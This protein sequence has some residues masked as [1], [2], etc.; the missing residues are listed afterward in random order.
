MYHSNINSICLE[1][2]NKM[3]GMLDT[4]RIL[5][6]T[7]EEELLAGKLLGDLGAD[8]I[9][10]ES[11]GG[12]NAR[13]IGPFYQDDIDPEKSLFWFAFNTSKKGVTLNLETTE[14]REIFKNLVKRSDCVIE[15]FPTGY[16][17]G[18]GI[19]YEDLEKLNSGIV[20]VSITPFGQSGPYKDYKASDIVTWAMGGEMYLSGDA[21]RPPV[22]VS[23]HSQSRMHA[24]VQASVGAVAALY[25][26]GLNG[27][28]QH[29]D[30]SVQECVAQVSHQ[31]STMM[32]DTNKE[33]LKRNERVSFGKV[34]VSRLWPCKDGYVIFSISTGAH[35]KRNNCPL[36]KLM[37]SKGVEDN[38]LFK[39][40]WENFSFG[41]TKQ[42]IID[43]IEEPIKKFFKM[44]T[45]KELLEMGVKYR[46]QVYPVSTTADIKESE[47]LAARGYWT[48][49][50]HTE[51]GINI[52]Y[53][54]AFVMASETPVK[55]TRRA[56]L[57]GEHNREV[58]EKELGLS[59]EELIVLK[60]AKVI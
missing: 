39:L 26:R 58:Y 19:G 20:M 35:A 47:Q 37:K 32:W 43:R 22:R 30:V 52:Q 55:I 8:V 11:P 33:L 12:C 6:L 57:I 21:D 17:D 4:Y 49:L 10:I 50:R 18:L 31:M 41:T 38:F 25:Y 51:L 5:D 16:L 28:G 53:P 9:K 56:P 13:K 34:H 46:V 60:N 48:E 59:Q 2:G 14:G 27:E 7:D 36:F 1:D 42:D 3:Q 29:V 15:S 45:K 44:F 40:D 24:A 23:H 54:G